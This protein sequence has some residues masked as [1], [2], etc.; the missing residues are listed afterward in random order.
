MANVFGGS[1]EFGVTANG[2]GFYAGSQILVNGIAVNASA[3]GQTQ[4][5]FIIPAAN[6]VNPAVLQVSVFNPSP[7]GGTSNSV[8]FTVYPPVSYTFRSA[9]YEYRNITG[10]NL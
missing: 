9:S 8:P 3:S 5:N 10:T 2:T 4:M 6:L 1:A 7:G